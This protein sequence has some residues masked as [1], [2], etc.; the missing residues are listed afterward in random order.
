LV[1]R[2]GGFRRITHPDPPKST[3]IPGLLREAGFTRLHSD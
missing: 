2:G 3:Q 1:Q